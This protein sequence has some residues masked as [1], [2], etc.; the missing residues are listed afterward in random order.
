MNEFINVIASDPALAGER[1][2]LK[3]EIASS[4]SYAHRPRNDMLKIAP[5]S[6]CANKRS[7][8]L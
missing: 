3:T 5:F 8:L 2:N 6:G 4:G 7:N 1:S